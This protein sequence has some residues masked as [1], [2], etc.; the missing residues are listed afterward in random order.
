M[1]G[2]RK[3]SFYFEI[4]T[5]IA[6]TTFVGLLIPGD[7][8]AVKGFERPKEEA[9][10][11]PIPP[12]KTIRACFASEGPIG[13]GGY[14]YAHY[15][16]SKEL[17]KLPYVTETTFVEN[18]HEGT[19]YP[20]WKRLSK[21]GYNMFWA[22]VFEYID[23]MKKIA[24]DYPDTI[25][26]IPWTDYAPGGNMGAYWARIY[27]GW[28]LI[29]MTAGLLTKTDIIGFIQCYPIALCYR[30]SNAFALG[31]KATNPKA[32]VHHLWLNKWF[33][34]AAE[35]QAYHS[36][37]ALGADIVAHGM[38]DPAVPSACQKDGV[39]STGIW[40]DMS[41]FA[42]KAV[43]TSVLCHWE[44]IYNYVAKQAHEGTFKSESLGWGVKEEM[45]E[46]S[47]FG[48]MVP[49]E[50]RVK[51]KAIENRMKEDDPT[52]FPFYGAVIDQDGK[53]RIPAGRRPT[54]QELFSMDYL[55]DVIKGPRK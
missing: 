51:I 12:M 28:Y 13:D 16:A 14:S 47:P 50:V 42:P 24:A 5:L 3:K 19:S 22:C 2:R 29:G 6:I 9:V 20:V 35:V 15:K 17:E 8:G 36:L 10:A 52:A 41:K 33:D 53:T 31:V 55:V 7:V 34:P 25:W 49:E 11:R 45:I 37:K 27:E 39:Y 38:D 44:K 40:S 26:M 4:V 48:P 32:S 30:D 18:V 54:S 1:K 46:L 23:D 43:L 21:Q